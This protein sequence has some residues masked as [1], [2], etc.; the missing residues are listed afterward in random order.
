MLRLWLICGLMMPVLLLWT[1]GAAAILVMRDSGSRFEHLL[2]SDSQA[3]PAMI[4]LIL[5][6]TASSILVYLFFARHLS[7][8]QPPLPGE[9][10]EFVGNAAANDEKGSEVA[11][12]H[13][14]STQNLVRSNHIN[15]AI[16][17]AVPSPVFVLGEDGGVI[18]VNPAAESLSE[19]LGIAGQL[20]LKIQRLLDECRKD[21]S[22]Y[23]PQDPRD[24]MVFRIN[25]EEV[26]F[27]PRIFHFESEVDLLSGWA[28]LLHNVSRIRWLDDMKTNHIATVSHEIKTPLTCI[29]MALLLLLEERTSTLDPI[30]R[31]LVTSASG[32]CE[33]LLT[34]VNSVLALSIAESGAT[35]L[36]RVPMS[37]HSSV[38]GIGSQ[39]E[40]TAA[41]RGIEL[42][43][44]GN[45]GSLPKVL[46]DPVR[47]AEVLGN[48]VSN[49]IN[50]SPQDGKIILRL[51]KPDGVHIRLSV[52][53]QGAGVPELSQPR[54]FERFY[55]APGQKTQR[56]G[57]G[58]F[59]SRDIMTAHEGRI[60]LLERNENLTEFFIDVPI[61]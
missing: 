58:L 52:I 10:N 12:Q 20:P 60:G 37:L 18:Q 32:D 56:L 53:D 45:D 43:I 7:A 17:E 46:A 34:T 48:L 50:H 15:R 28:V 61:A 21:Q 57:L 27:L 40:S 24:A 23:L 44:E 49:A 54:I 29:R 59:I 42:R 13:D 39:F 35:H 36:N 1:M 8:A 16:L 22:N 26:F 11:T 41:K 47:L 9:E 3:I 51:S 30:Q 6:G 55:R 4:G 31:T 5:L 38:E 14:Q 33:R 2:K 25:D 19:N